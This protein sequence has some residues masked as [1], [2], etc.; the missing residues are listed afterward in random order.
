MRKIK[1]RAWIYDVKHPIVPTMVYQKDMD[2]KDFVSFGQCVDYWN[3]GVYL[4]Q[5]TGLL[6]KNGVEIYEGDI[7][8]THIYYSDLEIKRANRN[9]YNEEIVFKYGRFITKSC[10][11]ITS[12]KFKD[13]EIIGNIYENPELLTS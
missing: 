7:V 13:H 8:K 10:D 4:M 11:D 9:D 1:F 5:F 12:H 2:C 6:D 3:D